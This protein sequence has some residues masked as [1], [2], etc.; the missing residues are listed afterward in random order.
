[1]ASP[2]DLSSSN[3]Q[4][5]ILLADPSLKDGNF[6]K[7]VVLLAEHSSEEGAFGLV[8]NHPTSKKV[9][10]L[11]PSEEFE[12]LA[13]IRV[14]VGGPVRSDHLTFAAMWIEGDLINFSTRMPAKQAIEYIKK[15]GTLV[16]AF[17]GYSGWEKDQLEG[18]LEHAAW[19]P[20][21]AHKNLLNQPHDSTLWSESLKGISPFHHILALA[22]ENLLAN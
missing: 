14:Y 22:P 19:H 9:G 5:K 20:I 15:P 7:S 18:E 13:A 16:H 21:P 6:F 11:L 3:L 1:M 10:E 8:L 2:S 4:G 17:I 12:P